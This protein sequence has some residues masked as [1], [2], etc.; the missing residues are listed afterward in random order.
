[1]SVDSVVGWLVGNLLL[2]ALWDKIYDVCVVITVAMVMLLRDFGLYGIIF[3]MCVCVCVV[4]TVA[5]VMLLGDF[6]PYGIIFMMC[7]LL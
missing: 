3:M 7:V 5:M 2:R 6:V 1:V 4:I